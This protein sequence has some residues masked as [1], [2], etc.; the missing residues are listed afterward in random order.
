MQ[1]ETPSHALPIA[2][3]NVGM[4]VADSAGEEVGTVTAVQMP[5]TDVRPELAAG[6]AER[7]VSAGYLRIDGSGLFA[8]DLFAAGDQIAGSV[9]GEPATVTLNVLREDLAHA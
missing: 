4:S 3:V 7:L 5:G 9:E 1:P 6:D 8:K 2:R